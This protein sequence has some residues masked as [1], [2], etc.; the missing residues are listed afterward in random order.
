M[1]IPFI[2]KLRV[3][4][5]ILTQKL[6]GNARYPLVLMLEPLFQCNLA[7]SGC[8]K[9]DYPK[10]ILQKRLTVQ[11]ALN[12]VDECNAPIVSIPGG[13][14]LIHEEIDKIVDG[15]LAKKK[16]VYLC[17]N[18]ILME[19]KLDLFKPSPYFAFSVHL[20][21]LKEKHDKSVCREGIYDKAV[22]AIEAALHQGFRVCVNCTLFTN[23]QPEKVADFFDFLM[24][25]GVEGITV[26][27]GYQYEKAPQKDV[28]LSENQS[29]KLFR[30]IFRF[31]KKKKWRFNHSP[32]YLDF[33]AGNQNYQCTPW[34][35]PT[36]NIFGWQK[37][38]YL[39]VTEGYAKSFSELMEATQW[40]KYGVGRNKK[41]D[42]CM[43]HCGFEGTAVNDTFKHPLKA[44]KLSITGPKTQG[45]L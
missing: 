10:P 6:K 8:G 3:G 17:T 4:S 35:N 43:A 15:I 33:L 21:G 9:I 5:Y 16:F 44:L 14:P 13:E 38:C 36:Y 34:A 12:A 30:A 39:L 31:G 41:C 11:Q 37:P 28:F 24:K 7:C 1:S 2:Q 22:S 19:K 20:D 27:P 29:V 32:L 18:A 45:S 40:E 42:N 25:L 23:E 26:S